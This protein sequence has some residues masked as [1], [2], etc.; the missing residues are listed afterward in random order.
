[1]YN[2]SEI[3]N[4]FKFNFDDAKNNPVNLKNAIKHEVKNLKILKTI[5]QRS[6]TCGQKNKVACTITLLIGFRTQMKFL[7]LQNLNP[8]YCSSRTK[9]G[10]TQSATAFQSRI[11]TLT[12]INVTHTKPRDFMDDCG[13]SFRKKSLRS[14][15]AAKVNGVFC[16]E[17]RITKDGNDQL[18]FK[19]MNTKNHAIY[20]DTNI[21][22]WFKTNINDVILNDIEEFQTKQ[23]GWSLSSIINLT[24]NINKYTPQLGS[25]YIELP[26]Q[27]KKKEACI[28]VKNEDNACFAWAIMSA[29]YP[30]EKHPQRVSK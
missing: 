27:I 17:F 26:L 8:K 13:K 3:V 1:M 10:Y 24:M 14:E 7:K 25:S 4:Q 22:E 16:G 6:K 15:I 29:L 28:N 18:E 30:V 19:Y 5:L 21:M 9:C 23:S 12:I 2:I 20:R 11:K